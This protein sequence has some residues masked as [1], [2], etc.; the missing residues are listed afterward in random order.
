[1]RRC[2]ET[3]GRLIWNCPASVLT[4]RSASRRRS[5]IRR[6]A[7]WLIAPKTSGSRSGVTTILPIYVSK[8]LRVKSEVGLVVL[9]AP[10]HQVSPHDT[11]RSGSV[12]APGDG[13]VPDQQRH[14]R[15]YL[16]QER[17]ARQ[18]HQFTLI[19]AGQGHEAK[20]R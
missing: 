2:W 9:D 8:H 15:G 17:H 10:V 16:G 20:E 5:S 18:P 11:P 3:A 19:L 6:R 7:G 13:P 14:V 12:G 1:M 4:E